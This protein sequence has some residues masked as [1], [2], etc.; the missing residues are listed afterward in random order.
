MA[1]INENTPLLEDPT[2]PATQTVSRTAAPD[3]AEKGWTYTISCELPDSL[4]LIIMVMHLFPFGPSTA[5][6][7]V[8]QMQ[9]WIAY[10]ICCWFQI[11]FCFWIIDMETAEEKDMGRCG[12]QEVVFLARIFSLTLFAA[13]VISDIVETFQ[14]LAWVYM[15]SKK[16]EDLPE[17]VEYEVEDEDGPPGT[18]QYRDSSMCVRILTSFF[19]LCSKAF[20]LRYDCLVWKP[21]R[22]ELQ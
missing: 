5:H 15:A 17:N 9:M 13:Y 21:F 16:K 7:V 18:V 6:C 4:Y 1:L 22:L 14:M 12:D 19:C 2:Q 8:Y 10:G 20:H 3:V 11:Q